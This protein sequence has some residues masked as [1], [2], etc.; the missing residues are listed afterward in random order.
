[1][2]KL[3]VSCTPKIS[4]ISNDMVKVFIVEDDLFFNKLI[5]SAF[6]DT[7]FDLTFFTN[8]ED[9]LHNLYQNPD[10]V[11][12]DYN[13]P[14]VKGVELLHKIK[15]FNKDI[16]TLIVSGQ[17]DIKV[18]VEAYT[19]GA[20]QYIIKNQN[21]IIEIK[22][23][24]LRLAE[25]NELK[26]EVEK[27]REQVIDRNKYSSIIGESK[28][29]LQ[30]IRLIQKIENSS[31]L[32]LITGESGTGKEVVA[33]AIHYSSSRKK[34]PFV[35]VNVAAIPTDLIE[36]ELFGHEKGAFT[37]AVSSR[38]GKFEEAEGGTIFL[39]EIGE[40]D[41]SI[42]TKL[43]RVLQENQ[44]SRLGSN[45]VINLD[46]RVIAATNKNL[47][48]R[49]KE[50]KFREDLYYRIQGFL[51]HLPPLQDRGTDVIILANHFLDQYSKSNRIPLKTLNNA[52]KKVLLNHPWTGNVRELK[53][54]IERSILINDD[55]IITPDDLIF[56]AP[57]RSDY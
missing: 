21:S 16:S 47:G 23:A 12:L 52:A 41:I 51:I 15:E 53:A 9:F 25:S 20:D 34:K 49:V 38:K 56:S 45:K 57:I 26:I 1:M 31:I 50:G 42:Q 30:V 33:K 17:D 32:T 43:L 18:V 24:V 10:I 44:I 8:G 22:K 55:G 27:L 3:M 29:I 11:S 6:V 46:V 7:D 5:Q 36:S 2:L 4:K 13:L 54:V 14:D 19:L 39:D 28:P 48:Q 40:M 37:G 35:A